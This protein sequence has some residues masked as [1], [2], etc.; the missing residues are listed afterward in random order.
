MIKFMG[1]KVE[2]QWVCYLKKSEGRSWV[3]RG[4]AGRKSYE[5]RV[6]RNEIGEGDQKNGNRSYR[7][8][9]QGNKNGAVSFV[10]SEHGN[11]I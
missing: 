4:T 7:N 3:L 1:A 10:K 9:V 6:A 8:G 2:K 5:I 11:K